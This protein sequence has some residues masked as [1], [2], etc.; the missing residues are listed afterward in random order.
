MSHTV[1]NLITQD[2]EKISHSF[3]NFILLRTFFVPIVLLVCTYTC[4]RGR[5][6]CLLSSPSDSTAC[7][8]PRMSALNSDTCEMPAPISMSVGTHTE[9]SRMGSIP[10][11]LTHIFPLVC[12]PPAH[13]AGQ[14][15]CL[16]NPHQS[17]F[18]QTF[19]SFVV[20]FPTGGYY[21][22][23]ILYKC[24]QNIFEQDARGQGM[25]MI[26][27]GLSIRSIPGIHLHTAAPPFQGPAR[28][29]SPQRQEKSR[30]DLL[31]K[32]PPLPSLERTL[33]TSICLS[34]PLQR[35]FLQR[36]LSP[37]GH[38]YGSHLFLPSPSS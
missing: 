10:L 17:H 32:E 18:P 4:T 38:G 3:T 30:C 14:C 31:P 1:I 20:L 26:N 36:H 25:P 13:W 19:L 16:S 12:P 27:N 9:P 2:T 11:C 37:L 8:S 29:P 21:L 15:T 22:E 23:G 5:L 28:T 7:L 34:K 24:C 35:L 6:T 33:L